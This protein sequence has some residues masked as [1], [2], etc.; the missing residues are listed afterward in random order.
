MASSRRN[1]WYAV[2]LAVGVLAALLVASCS[3]SDQ[4]PSQA[5]APPASAAG[6]P[7]F[8]QFNGDIPAVAGNTQCSL[9]IINGEPAGNA[10]SVAGAS[11]VTFGG[12]AG[13]GHGQ[14]AKGSAL[15]LKGKQRS[16]SVP[17]ATGVPRTD[18]AKALN[19][20]GMKK[21][22][23]NLSASL[24]ATGEGDYALYVAAPSN[25]A[26]DCDLHR[27]LTVR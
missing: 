14:A 16:Y 3:E 4:Q 1:Q 12:W 25:S 7:A 24:A 26:E 15:V 9:D 11:T 20:D 17:L 22:G 18:V 6:V 21:S 19:S 13:D 8:T 10:A 27:S 23:F 5:A 2:A